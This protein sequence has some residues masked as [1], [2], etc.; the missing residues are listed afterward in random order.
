MA[1]AIRDALGRPDIDVEPVDAS[2]FPLPA[3]RGRSEAIRSLALERL[4][5]VPR[6]WREAL[7]EY[8]TTELAPRL[9]R[10]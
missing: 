4:G 3:P 1:L 7:A 5:L 8:V 10:A 6:P 9:R 2:V